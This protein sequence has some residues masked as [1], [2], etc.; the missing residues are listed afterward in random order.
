MKKQKI[1]NYLK[2]GILLF[3]VSVFLWNCE[4]ITETDLE[5]A[6]QDVN[7]ILNKSFNQFLGNPKFTLAIKELERSKYK[8]KSANKLYDF[9]IDST[10]IREI[11]KNK[12]VTYTF[13][14]KRKQKDVSYFENLVVKVDSLNKTEAL[15]LKYEPSEAVK[16]HK[17]HNSLSFIGKVIATPLSVK[18][19]NFL[20]REKICINISTTYCTQ[21]GPGK[22]GTTYT[23]THIA[24]SDCWDKTQ[25]FTISN[26]AC[27][28]D[29]SN[30]NLSWPV[31]GSGDGNKEG[32]G[33]GFGD[34]SFDISPINYP[35]GD[36]IHGCDV[37]ARQLAPRLGVD[38][39]LLLGLSQ[40]NLEKIEEIATAKEDLSAVIDS[41]NFDP[42]ND[43]WLKLL[44][45][46][47]KLVEFSKNISNDLYEEFTFT[48]D[49]NLKNTLNRVARQL[50][51]S[52]YPASEIQR[53]QEFMY[54]GK[55]GVAILLY[56]FANGLGK[57]KRSF[58][59]DFDITKQM[60]AG[61]VQN[62]IKADFFKQ[63]GSKTFSQFISNM[64]NEL[65]GG[66]AF[67]PGHTGVVDSFNKHV[68]ANWVQFFV[69]GT[70]AKYYPSSD[71]G[72]IIVELTNE[73]S[74]NSLLLHVGANYDRN[75]TGINRPLSTI[76]QIFRFKL[77]IQ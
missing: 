68:N 25:Q 55:A 58:S 56:E 29:G 5:H 10:S 72:W 35:C 67:S 36:P 40:I 26:N 24:N 62:D 3:G 52:G 27:F 37:Y 22:S 47:A 12:T 34:G 71:P 50:D 45:E 13:F 8:G 54:D 70:R 19:I 76:K 39:S 14:V 41:P 6:H 11:K 64:N 32:P 33:G 2:T 73:T 7:N 28:D 42:L 69:G 63:L 15:L 57:D 60:I 44:R 18:K 77:K 46:F 48:L 17:E 59:S 30:G 20:A 61:N 66:Y 43:T 51:G 1:A 38:S 16:F 53:E 31:D 9:T 65:D 4:E 74:R 49:L 23:G 21:T 75:G